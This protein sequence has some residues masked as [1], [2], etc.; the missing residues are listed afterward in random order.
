MILK[1]DGKVTGKIYVFNGVGS[2]VDVDDE[3]GEIM[4]MKTSAQPCCGE[5]EPSLYFQVVEEKK[6]TSTRRT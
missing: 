5:G 2:I 1:I 6:S 3:D 4:K